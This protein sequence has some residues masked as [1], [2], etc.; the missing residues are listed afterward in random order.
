M[1]EMTETETTG[2]KPKKKKNKESHNAVER[3][4]KEKINAGINR[5]GNLLPCSQAL[6][7]SKNMILDQA[8]RYITELKK[9]NDT[10]LLEGGD[11]IQAEE[12]RRLRRHCEELRKESAHYIELLKAHDINLLED[13]TVHWKGKQRC[14]K[15]TK[16]TPTHQLPK[17]IIVYSNG[18]VMCPAGKESSPG[19]QP[20]ETLILQPPSEVRVNGAL[21]QVTSSATSLH[22]GSSVTQSTPGLAVVEQCVVEKPPPP[23]SVSYITLQLPAV[24][25]A[26]PQPPAAPA[27]TNTASTS[28]PQL[29][30]PVSCLATMRDT[31]LR[32]AIPNSQTLLR[33]GAAGSTQT[34]WTTLQMAGNTV[35]P[36]CQSLGSAT[37]AV[38]Q[39]T[40][41]PV[42]TKS[43][44]VQP[45]QIQ[46]Q[47]ARPP[48]LRPAIPVL[49][50]QPAAVVS[51]SASLIPPVQQQAAVLP[52]LQTMQVLQVNPS[53]AAATAPQ[54]ANNASVVILQQ[55]NS[56]PSQPVV[57]EEASNPAPCQHIVII[58]APNQAPPAPQNP[59]GAA[60]SSLPAAQIPNSS[61]SVGGKQ[62][63][64]ILP[65]P[66]QP[67]VTSSM[68]QAPAA[69][70]QTITVNGQVFALQPMKTS[71]KTASQST[72]QLIQPTTTEEP[73][74]NVALKSLGALSSLNQSICQG[75][76]LS[77]SN[78]NGGSP[79]A[80]AQQKRQPPATA[81]VPQAP[82][83][84]PV[85]SAPSAGKRLRTTHAKRSTT[86]RTKA[87]KK[88]ELRRAS[89]DE[90]QKRSQTADIPAVAATTA[91]AE[92][93][94]SVT[95]PQ[96]SPL[97]C[98]T[99]SGTTGV[100]QPVSQ[101]VSSNPA[102]AIVSQANASVAATAVSTAS[103]TPSVSLAAAS[104]PLESEANSV[105]T[106]TMQSD[107]ARP[108]PVS[109]PNKTDVTVTSGGDVVNSTGAAC[110]TT[111]VVLTTQSS[112]SASCPQRPNSSDPLPCSAPSPA[113][114]TS[115][116][117]PVSAG[118]TQQPVANVPTEIKLP[119]PAAKAR[120]TQEENPATSLAASSSEMTPKKDFV[121]SHGVYTNLD[122]Q[123]MEPAVTDSAMS[124]AAAAGRGFSVASMLPQGQSVSAASGSFGT[125]SFT[126]EQAE[127]LAL[128]M[129]EQDSPG[130]RCAGNDA[131]QQP[132][133]PASKEKP[134]NAQQVKATKPVEAA[135]APAQPVR[136]Q[137][138]DGS[139][140]RHPPAHLIT[141]SQSQVPTQSS[142]PCGTVAS[143]SVN[144][145]IR[146]SSQ[147]A[148]PAS[149]PN[150]AGQQ[151]SAP[152]PAAT[153][154]I[155]QASNNALS[156]CSQLNEFSPMKT[157]L[158]RAQVERQVKVLSK[159]QAQE[160]AMLNT[161][162][163]A[164]PC[165]PPPPPPTVGHMDVKAAD[166]G[167]MMVGQLPPSSSTMA[168]I[169]SEG[170][171]FSTNSF[172]STVVRAADTHCPP[173]QNQ[174]GVL[175]PQHPAAQ[176]LGGNLYMKQQ[177]QQEQQRHHLYHLQHHPSQ[178][179][180]AQR[181]SLHQRALQQDK[182]R[183][184]VRG[185]QAGSPAAVAAMQQKQHHLDK[186]A[187]QQQQHSHPQQAPHQQQTH[188]QSHQP[189]QHQQSH[190]QQHQTHQQ[191]QHHQ[192]LQQQQQ[193]QQN[194]H[195]RHQ[196]HLQQQI[197][198]Q[199]HFRHQDKSCEAQAAGGRAHH[200]NHLAQ[201]DHLKPSQDHAAMQRMMTSRTLDQQLMSPPGNPASRSS[202]LT[203]APSSRQERHRVSNYSAEALIGKSSTSADPQQQQRLAHH[204]QPG[205]SG[206]QGDLRGY[207]DASARG[208]TNVAAVAHNPQGRLPSDHP[209]SECP[210]FKS[211][212][213]PPAHQLTAFE[214]QVS[215]GSDMAPKSQRAQQQGSF[216]MG[217][218]PPPDGRN[219]GGG[220]GGY[221]GVHL[222]PHVQ[223]ACHQSFMQSLLSP[224]G[225]HQRAPQC[226]PPVT[227][228]YPCASGTSA[229]DIQAKASS[230]AHKPP[231]I[232]KSHISQVNMHG[233]PG[234]ARPPL[235]QH[236]RLHAQPAKL[237]PAG[238]RPR[239]GAPR[240]SNPFEP[241]GHLP[242]PSS[243]G[244]LL[245]RPQSG[246]S[247]VV[248]FMADGAQPPGD[249]NLAGE[250]HLAQNFGFPFIP[251]GGMNPPAI[252]ANASF[253]PPVSQPGAS[254]TPSLLPVEA[255]SS[256]PSFY[257]PYSPAAHP[258]LPGDVALPYFPNQMFSSPGG[259]DKA[260]A[261]PALNNRFGSILSPPRGV[262]F[263]Q[264]SFPLLPDMPPMPIGNSSG[265]T[266]HLS[267][268]SLTSL[269]PEMAAGMAA[270]GSAMPMSPLLSLANASAADSG[271]QPNRPAHNISH[272]LGHDGSSAV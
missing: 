167:Q 181:H 11:R 90:N 126:S 108:S 250:Q 235:G 184:L 256:L 177:Q 131:W 229:A 21:L 40:V 99:S 245:G 144:N 85:K 97:V 146:P 145:L 176:H 151:C 149:S 4:R 94:Q 98:V 259:A 182:K 233:R 158:M 232:N 150:L 148:Y 102:D 103:V 91:S 195:S 31:A 244:V 208:K 27:Q 222:G 179:D 120:Q 101:S 214:A 220:G 156:P 109:K 66:A 23:P 203:C 35:Q 189:A 265:I 270:D 105:A 6:K 82:H 249:N 50:P 8:F 10:M 92:T 187:V 113:V 54:S 19:K 128:A 186:S 30:P 172:M 79:P 53:G 32:T 209:G 12:I 230:P 104:K 44:P 166:H 45:I 121:P 234:T 64:H 254:R 197:Q 74:T 81:T 224:E 205:R 243:G 96:N 67:P 223:D 83:P 122:D 69:T 37:Q 142:A 34:T 20:S 25:A 193:Q 169:N 153:G 139:V 100:S 269:F 252:N 14:A 236:S 115:A 168:R 216:R 62:L 133:G 117:P 56:C 206:E 72:I 41:C 38:H 257:P 125:F 261:P 227:M 55:A 196:Q 194:S 247:A 93:V 162:K 154:H 174:P 263:A 225:N 199:Q 75:L 58:Q 5:I 175:H 130:R 246:R 73:T 242:L 36:V 123:T 219:R 110:P 43:P 228:E 262:G 215:R 251:E 180:P 70:P 191:Q 114:S 76:P 204:L 48:Q 39:V 7:Q 226:C 77:Q 173:E 218:A 190:P 129:L 239:P 63:V 155:S 16:V 127:M 248:R 268:F 260:S 140:G 3:H 106:R 61:T 141:Y 147:Q 231:A 88:S 272:I 57:R 161:A 65:R 49:A 164:K 143:L 71:D 238:E 271:K 28:A 240:P 89:S 163:R 112:Q 33:A 253:I 13:P 185:S 202:D 188:Q 119:Q 217:V 42:V 26:I 211:M 51:Q 80:A 2:R 213:G 15:V 137:V 165:P 258:S 255:Q 241:E 171:L 116:T 111:A 198:Q 201:Q 157:A 78:N 68:S 152:S 200:S 1:P 84:S 178:P 183:G 138:G 212:A 86:K 47:Q 60:P 124:T 95:S 107:S 52:L 24:N 160:E 159:R 18:N 17:G 22:S 136:G 210:P 46:M 207:M 29:P 170:S 264:A 135:K 118:T 59:A 221:A 87:S 132:K 134:S 9:Q 266:P 267:N 192:Q 237:R